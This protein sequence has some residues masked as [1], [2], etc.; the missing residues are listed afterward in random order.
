MTAG[1][2]IA[3]LALIACGLMGLLLPAIPGMPLVFVG[4]AAVAWADGFARIGVPVLVV[5]GVLGVMGMVFDYLAGLLGA[6]RAG[7][8]RWGL[9]GAV[10]GLLVGLPFGLPG[11]VLGPGLGAMALEYAKDADVRRSARAGVG[12][13][14]GFILGTALKYAVA[15]TMLGLA[16]FAYFW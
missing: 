16:L 2:Y 7:A 14:V 6:K 3:G 13:L 15:M 4:I 9:I 11:L 12:V 1:L 10:V 5:I 8:S